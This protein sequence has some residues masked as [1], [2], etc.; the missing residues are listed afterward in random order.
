MDLYPKVL[1]I[2]AN[3]LSK[4]SNNGKTYA[5]FFNGY[6]KENLAQLYFHREIPTSD[7]CDNYYKISDEDII[8]YL[9]RKNSGLG[10][11]VYQTD[12]ENRVIPKKANDFLKK[13]IFIR[14]LRSLFWLQINIEDKKLNN[15]LN[16]F[17]PQIIFF[18]G[19]NENYLYNFT[20]ELS[21]KF[22]AKILYYIT[23]DYVLPYFS[24]NPFYLINRYW[25]HHV[26]ENMCRNS[27]LIFTIGDKM[28]NIYKEKYGITS[29]KIMNLVYTGDNKIDIDGI[30]IEN[31]K[32][33]FV[34]VG[35]LHS[36]RWK[37][38]TS[39]SK[40]LERIDNKGY[41]GKLE[42]YSKDTLSHN[43][44][45]KLNYKSYSRF[46]GPLNAD[47]VKKVLAR[48]DILVH[49]ESFDHISK[50]ITYLSIST[51][52]PEYMSS[53]KCIL[54]IGPKDV[55]S[56]E[57][58]KE[59]NSGFV[60]TSTTDQDIDNITINIFQKPNIRDLYIKQALLTVRQNHDDVI[61]R[62]EFQ[63]DIINL[64]K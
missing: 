13:S 41:K 24:F 33:T 15:W 16:C 50:R 32:L 62:N 40:C 44:L 6:P 11:K 49:V 12:I 2:T 30:D 58:I 5:S 55:A 51:K 3:P 37:T 17:N 42:I 52:I 19:G 4:T 57:Y 18:C 59:T 9:F 45:K 64:Y 63:Q 43:I 39:L 7:I 60:I 38:L 48:A 21:K 14:F 47:G 61:K 8:K 23:D 34:Y 29:K 31:N 10:G 22:N 26:F 35:G 54:A 28:S 27:S 1:I 56:I 20:I 46:C 25:A 36:S 53:G